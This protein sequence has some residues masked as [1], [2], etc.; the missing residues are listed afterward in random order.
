MIHP[1][2]STLAC[3]RLTPTQHRRSQL[4]HHSNI[5]N[6]LS[7]RKKMGGESLCIFHILSSY[8]F[9]RLSRSIP[10]RIA[11]IR[12]KQLG[13]TT[14]D[15]L[16][17]SLSPTT[18]KVCPKKSLMP[19]IYSIPAAH[20]CCSLCAAHA[21]AP[22]DHHSPPRSV[23]LVQLLRAAHTAHPYLSLP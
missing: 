14:L 10:L 5:C 16:K 23:L 2:P 6:R 22:H 20:V 12:S 1:P 11:K 4:W 17:K 19:C 8:T 18:S 3:V 15:A 9:L 21:A 13:P 7:I